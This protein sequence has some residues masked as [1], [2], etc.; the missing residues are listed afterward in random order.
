MWSRRVRLQGV[1][2]KRPAVSLG[3]WH[4]LGRGTK[5]SSCAAEWTCKSFSNALAGHF[6][7]SH[8]LF[9]A[10][11]AC[12]ECA[13]SF[14]VCCAVCESRPTMGR[15]WKWVL[16]DNL[17]ELCGG[18]EKESDNRAD[19]ESRREQPG[20]GPIKPRAPHGRGN[21]PA[22]EPQPRLSPDERVADARARVSRL[23][24]ALK[25]LGED[26]PEAQ[27]IKDVLKKAQDQ[28]C[29]LPV[30]E[31]GFNIEV[32]PEI[33]GEDRED[34]SRVGSRTHALAASI[35]SL[36]RL[37]DEAANSVSEPPHTT[38]ALQHRWT[39]RTQRRRS[40]D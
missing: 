4:V 27:P 16:E 33:S 34:S 10:P 26:S 21:P 39:S 24:A 28:Y 3:C 7:S 23:E 15:K 19:E 20:T 29:V 35:R 1:G 12:A 30:A 32:H 2:R 6:G 40:G 37:R 25:V 18:V 14:V 36:E 5:P 8:F 9:E 22:P 13:R 31:I 38:V 17:S 11:L